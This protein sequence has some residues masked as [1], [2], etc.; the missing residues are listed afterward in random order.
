MN[1]L[2]AAMWRA[3]RILAYVSI[4]AAL[5]LYGNK[6]HPVITLSDCLTSPEI[7]D[8]EIIEVGNEAIVDSVYADG[9]SIR[10]L[11]KTVHVA[12]DSKDAIPGEFIL[13][14]ARFHKPNSLEALEFRIAK[15]R[16]SK[17]WVSAI[18]ALVVLGYFIRR[19]RFN[20]KYF[21]FLDR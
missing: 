18:P 5:I 11:G 19:Y 1:E 6:K 4:L 9:F 10:Q 14:L 7:H 8:G 12:G 3:A 16:R 13:L 15:N 21:Y 2:N 17:I 20:I